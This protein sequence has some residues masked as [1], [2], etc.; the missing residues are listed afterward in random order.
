MVRAKPAPTPAPIPLA[1]NASAVDNASSERPPAPESLDAV[2]FHRLVPFS[3]PLRWAVAA[4]PPAGGGTRA[5]RGG[6]G[7]PWLPAGD[8]QHPRGLVRAGEAV[9]RPVP[10]GRTAPAPHV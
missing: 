7:E 6:T 8:R 3:A 10:D 9:H 1:A 5:D 4:D 2:D